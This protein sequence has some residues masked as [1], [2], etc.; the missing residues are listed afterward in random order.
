M[1]FR[2]QS[3]SEV[4][5]YRCLRWAS[6]DLAL[7]P[8]REYTRVTEISGSALQQKHQGIA[9]RLASA[10]SREFGFGADIT[11]EIAARLEEDL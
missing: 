9:D 3:S 5:Q 1:K 4:N 11:V 6:S 7:L 2:L 8:C 10:R